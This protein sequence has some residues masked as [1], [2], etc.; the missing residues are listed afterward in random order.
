MKCQICKEN[1]AEQKH[2]ISYW[3]DE[4]TID[5][6]IECHKKIHKH[7]VGASRETNI[8]V[9]ED[10]QPGIRIP[11]SNA[12]IFSSF[13]CKICLEEIMF[14]QSLINLLLFKKSI[15]EP[16]TKCYMCKF[17]SYE[18]QLDKSFISSDIEAYFVTEKPNT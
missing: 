16:R 3:P 15:V 6:C 13:K 12:K 5:I 14:S 8:E 10:G 9:I 2:H 7:P 1:V 11:L 4:L 18:F 17:T